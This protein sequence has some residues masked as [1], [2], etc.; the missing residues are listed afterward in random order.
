ML[1][2]FVSYFPLIFIF[3]DLG[4]M[5]DEKEWEDCLIEASGILEPVQLRRLFGQILTSN[6]VLNPRHLWDLF[7]VRTF[8]Q[9]IHHLLQTKGYDFF[10]ERRDHWDDKTKEAQ[11]LHHLST[12]LEA[13]GKTLKDYN[14]PGIIIQSITFFSFLLEFDKTFLP[15]PEDCVDDSGSGSISQDWYKRHADSSKIV[16]RKSLNF[17]ELSLFRD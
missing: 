5:N 13:H 7:T 11:A 2:R 14:L 1:L 10:Y 15:R 3:K 8:P 16:S 9:F 4:L 17:K 12:Y 6:P